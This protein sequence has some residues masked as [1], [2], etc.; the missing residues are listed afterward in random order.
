MSHGT[1]NH[2]GFLKLLSLL[3]HRVYQVAH[4]AAEDQLLVAEKH[5]GGGV[6]VGPSDLDQPLE[7]V[8]ATNGILVDEV[9]LERVGRRVVGVRRRPLLGVDLRPLQDCVEAGVFAVA[10]EQVVHPVAVPT[11]HHVHRDSELLA[12]VDVHHDFERK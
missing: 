10:L 2:L 9:D 12:H 6:D 7:L 4:E 1:S 5:V 3:S 11:A 8:L